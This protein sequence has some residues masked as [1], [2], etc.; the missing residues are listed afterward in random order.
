MGKIKIVVVDDSPF[1]ISI[2]TE[3][4]TEKGFEVIGNASSLQET[5]EVVESKRPDLVTMDMTMPG[6]DGLECTRAIHKIDPNIKV[7]IVSSMMDDEIVTEARE[8]KVSG[9]VQKPVQPDEIATAIQ[10]AM[11]DE[12]LFDDLE[13]IYFN[14]FKEVFSDNMNRIVKEA[15]A[16]EKE[17]TANGTQ[18]SRGISIVV[19][20]IGK[21][22]GSMILDLSYETAEAMTKCA[23]KRE[24]KNT[25]ESLAM[26]GEFA[27]IISGNACSLLNRKNS[28]FGFRVAPPTIFH[29]TS[30]NVSRTI[31]DAKSI[32]AQTI[33]GEISLNVGFK[34]GAN[35]WM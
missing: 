33:F 18:A 35:E 27:N 17:V 25:E 20:I 13:E 14:V 9:Y 11:V 22:C 26:M 30:L 34:R 1:S 16:F 32:I 10:R 29:G 19:G 12:K 6:T 21:Y 23:L 28:V 8:N 24:M 31:L 7:I 3:I 4:L 2:I 15:P 5:I